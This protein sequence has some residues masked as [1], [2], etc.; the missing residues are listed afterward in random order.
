VASTLQRL[1]L[2]AL[3]SALERDLRDFLALHVAPLVEPGTLLAKGVGDKARERFAK[4]SSDLPTEQELLEYLDLGEE[5][6]SIRVNDH[7]LDPA[8]QTYIQKYYVGLEGLVAVRNRV[9]HSRPLEFD[10]LPRVSDLASEL[11]RSHRALWA[12]LRTTRRTLERDPDFATTLTIPETPDQSTKVLHNLPLTEFDDTGF[13]GRKKEL[14]ELKAA[15]SGSYPVVT[16]VGEGG[17]GKTAI[18]LKACYELLDDPNTQF[19][20]I[21]WTTAK[22]TKL[23][24]SEI[25]FIE[26]A[27]SSSIGIIE[28]AA[29]L[30]GRQNESSAID[31]LLLHLTNNKIL[32]VIDN[33]E[34]VVDQNIRS[35][36]RR[37]PSGSRILLTTRI[38]LGA[39]DF[40]I[41]LA[42]LEK[43][44]SNFYFRRTARVWGLPTLAA[45]SG[46]I[47]DGYCDRL[48]HNPLFIK[49]F[50]QSVRAGKRPTTLASDPTTLLQFCLQNVFN[51][52]PAEA[53][54]IGTVLANL[55]GPQSVASLAYYCDVDSIG[56]QSGL[57]HLITSNLVIAER[58]RSSEDED[59]YM[60]SPLARMY[61]HK[62]IVL[63]PN[64]QR[65]LITKQNALRS[66][67]EEFSARAGADNFD[68]NFVYVR[69]KDDYIVAKMLTRAIEF[70]FKEEFS[71]AQELI[72][73]A[74]DLSPN[75]F[76]VHR[77]RALL[78]VGRNDIF[79]ANAE[80]QAAISLA[81]ERPPLR[82]WYAI[83]LSRYLGDQPESL[84][85]L[86][87]AEELAPAS[88]LVKLQVARI[89]QF[90]RKFEEAAKRLS[91]IPDIEK[92]SAK[93]RRI[94]LDLR[95]QNELRRVEQ[96]NT[97]EDYRQALDCYEQAKAVFE[98]APFSLIDKKTIL[99]VQ[100]S[101]RHLAPLRRAFRGLAEESRLEEIA[102]WVS[103]PTVLLKPIL[104]A[105]PAVKGILEEEIILPEGVTPPNRGRLAQLHQNY[106]FI[107]TGGSRVFFHRGGWIGKIDFLS[108]GDGTIVDF[109]FGQNE[110]GSC[111]I[112]VRPI[113]ESSTRLE[114]GARVSGTVKALTTTYG[115]LKL[116][117]GGDLFFHS[118]YCRA[119]TVFKNLQIGDRIK[120]QYDLAPDGR[121]RAVDCERIFDQ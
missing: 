36:V 49:W 6:Q 111:A 33:L 63:A 115:F 46:S 10:D 31:D 26:G 27:I 14:H 18:A 45:E 83:F 43:K 97:N 92:L 107:D 59:R 96:C 99:H 4:D 84:K 56:I 71:Q 100:H 119:G 77:V 52:L 65:A 61:I 95:L 58:G 41:P 53:K 73:R 66:A 118:S 39:F 116:D 120:C 98:S 19:D 64:E 113:D 69:D 44:D 112:A 78:N 42:P 30:L 54:K 102:E 20:A 72:D 21:V 11:V 1:T 109:E 9:M 38:G 67:Q 57:T 114:P 81:P 22:T 15:L 76:E 85:Q 103:N 86:L 23:T 110:Q 37:V 70:I 40:P 34:T 2:Y 108:L 5:I 75:Y 51:T 8:T 79:S 13:I 90:Q 17:L 32:L 29:T 3:L 104:D 55:S 7:R 121:R 87:K 62:F 82:M 60:I 93:I 28:S 48:Q 94:H 47:V 35:L 80:Y 74:N 101:G 91:D 89:L 24:V 117:T 12:N 25:Q 106:G 68:I 105:D 88:A 16:V 50:I